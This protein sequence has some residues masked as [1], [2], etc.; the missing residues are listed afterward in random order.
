MMRILSE[1]E[2]MEVTPHHPTDSNEQSIRPQLRREPEPMGHPVPDSRILVPDGIRCQA[3]T[4]LLK[5]I[6]RTWTALDRNG[7]D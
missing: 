4:Q 2:P 7:I 3:K 5:K 6:Q 1:M